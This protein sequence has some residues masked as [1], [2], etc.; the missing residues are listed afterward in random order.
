MLTQRSKKINDSVYLEQK[1]I[2]QIM[3][4]KIKNDPRIIRRILP[5]YI[6]KIYKYL[7][8]KLFKKNELQ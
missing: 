4:Q 7:K 5:A 8:K 2:K 6:Y 3:L 1:K